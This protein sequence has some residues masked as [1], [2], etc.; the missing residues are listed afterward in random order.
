MLGVAMPGVGVELTGNINLN[1][2]SHINTE[3]LIQL[4][5]DPFYTAK[6]GPDPNC[7]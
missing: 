1:S 7:F 6:V 3:K 2:A 4:D 5:S